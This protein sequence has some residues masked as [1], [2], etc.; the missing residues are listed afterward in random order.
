VTLIGQDAVQ[1]MM[2]DAFQTIQPDNS[3]APAHP[4][5]APCQLV[6]REGVASAA[7]L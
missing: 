2:A 5:N 6:I 7:E 3:A 1:A 4:S